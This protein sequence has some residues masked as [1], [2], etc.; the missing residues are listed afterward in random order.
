MSSH[1]IHG[2]FAAGGEARAIVAGRPIWPPGELA[3]IAAR[4]GHPQ[5]V[6]AAWRAEG[7]RFL[8]R[9]NGSFAIAATDGNGG[10]M[11]AVDRF[12]V[13]RMCYAGDGESVRFGTSAERVARESHHGAAIDPNALYHYLYFHTVPSPRTIYRDVRK[14]PPAH[15]ALWR[16][17]HLQVEPYWDHG[18]AVEAE[19]SRDTL[20]HELHRVIR[21]SVERLAPDEATGAFLSG[22][23]DSSTVTGVLGDV[24]GK[25]ARTFTIGFDAKEYDETRFAR[26]TVRHFKAQATEYF[27]TPQDTAGALPEIAAAYDEP[28]GNSS[29]VPTLLCARAARAAGMRRLLAGDGGDELY[30]GNSRYAKQQ[31]FDLWWRVPRALRERVL[32]P[33]LRSRALAWAGPPVR[34]ARSY[35]AQ[36]SVPMPDRLQTY[37]FLAL[38]PPGEVLDEAFHGVVDVGSP[39]HD[40]RE[41]YA[42]HA[43]LP[44]VDAMLRFDWKL[45]LA[46]N[47]LRKVVTMCE[48]AG[49]DVDFPFLDNEVVEHSMRVPASYKIRRF[50][51]RD[52]YKRAMDGY[53]PPEVIGK[54]KHGFGL[55]FGTWLLSD[56]GLRTLAGDSLATFRGRRIVAPR[57][58]DFLVERHQTEHAGYYGEF[59]WVLLMLEL[60]L[61]RHAPG[62]RF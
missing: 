37:N 7:T 46:D 34:K 53:L 22:G 20:A 62:T 55:P 51:L 41:W 50:R 19:R 35:V 21:A 8:A 49:I 43:R 24:T 10:A 12:G 15:V 45:T 36:A 14:L 31:V 32:G 5:A 11:L 60:W 27:V 18:A 25:P 40:M 54:T 26:V 42:R 56:A 16:P 47:D 30:G 29:A 39:V 38:T 33:A 48:L 23:I 3:D 1:V 2:S 58:L 57:Y 17:G 61:Q 59:V 28:F 6:L 44:L 13:Q 9:L 4:Q 52:F